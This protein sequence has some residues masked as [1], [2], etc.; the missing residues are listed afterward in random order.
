M[1][2]GSES[3]EDYVPGSALASIDAKIKEM[4]DKFN[5]VTSKLLRYIINYISL[6]W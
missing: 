4:E 6:L 2:S 3:H 5:E 1:S